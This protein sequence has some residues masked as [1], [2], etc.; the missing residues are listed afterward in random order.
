MKN[1]TSFILALGALAFMQPVLL[2]AQET[3]QQHG[4]GSLTLIRIEG[5]VLLDGKLDE[6]DWDRAERITEF[7]QKDPD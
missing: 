2:A 7:I 5:E 6:D 3:G 1:T 4:K